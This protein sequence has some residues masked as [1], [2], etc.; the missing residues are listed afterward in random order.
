MFKTVDIPVE[1]IPVEASIHGELRRIQR[2]I[3]VRDLQA[4][5]KHG[6]K[7]KGHPDPQTRAKR[8]QYTYMDIVYI[9][10]ETS[11]K[12]ITSWA[13]PLPLTQLGVLCDRLVNQVTEANR[14]IH[15]N[16]SIITAHT[17]LVVDQSGSMRKSGKC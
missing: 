14:R 2:S 17:V 7:Q 9:T 11:T 5:V 1:E 15:D 4:A 13:Q 8:W 10:D 16:P 3:S 12:E 6:I